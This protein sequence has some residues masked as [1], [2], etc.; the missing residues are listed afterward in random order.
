MKSYGKKMKAAEQYFPVVP[1]TMLYK[2]VQNR[3]SED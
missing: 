1:F 3:E 2:L